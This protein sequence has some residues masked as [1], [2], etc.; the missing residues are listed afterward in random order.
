VQPR[1]GTSE[2][3]PG[4]GTLG[5]MPKDP[6]YVNELAIAE[7]G[8]V[9][10]DGTSVWRHSHVRSGATI[11]EDTLLG[12]NVYV[13]EGAVIGNRVTIQNNVSVYVGVTLEDDVFVG[14]SAVFTNDLYPRSRNREWT[15]V[16]TR[17]RTG[18]SVCAN[19][20]VVCGVEIGE[21]SVVAAGAVVTKDVAP[22]EIVAGNPARRMGWACR[23]GRVASRDRE[24]PAGEPRCE[25]HRD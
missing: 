9:I 11:G 25:L 5:P 16:E 19:A 7:P 3:G 12:K 24:P 20:T 1:S 13:D 4:P 10:G 14:P 17:V 21:W 18:A 22:F 6:P 2:F 23:C 8:A 15:L